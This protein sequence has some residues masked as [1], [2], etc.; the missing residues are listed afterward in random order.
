MLAAPV[1]EWASL[2]WLQSN[3]QLRGTH[4]EK[5]DL[6]HNPLCFP[7]AKSKVEYTIN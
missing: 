4:E 7:G 1:Q 2:C 3:L 5:Q 6:D